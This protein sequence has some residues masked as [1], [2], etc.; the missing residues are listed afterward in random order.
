MKKNDLMKSVLSTIVLLFVVACSREPKPIEYGTDSCH[1]CRMAIVDKVHGA[2][3]VTDKG[4][5]FKFDAAECLF[6][7]KKE[8]EN[9]ENF[10]FLTNY[11]ESPG[12]FVE[13]QKANF[14]VSENMPSPMGANLTAFKNQEEVNKVKS[15][16]GGEV[17]TFK[18]MEEK[19]KSN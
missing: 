15:E 7:Y 16:K 9:T 18:E 11:F 14:L 10:I 17:Y 12:E 2:E 1:F 3:I 6:N 5:V 13:M 8:L 19:F 4:K